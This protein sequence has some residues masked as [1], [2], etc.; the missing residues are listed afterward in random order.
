MSFVLAYSLSVVC[1]NVVRSIKYA[2]ALKLVVSNLE[3]GRLVHDLS[4]LSSA[5][6]TATWQQCWRAVPMDPITNAL[7]LSGTAPLALS[8][9][10]PDDAFPSFRR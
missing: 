5:V 7:R 10:A 4:P 2:T 6:P 3:Q 1:V 9:A 8:V